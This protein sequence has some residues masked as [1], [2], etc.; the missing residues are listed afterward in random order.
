MLEIPHSK[1]GLTNYIHKKEHKKS[2]SKITTKTMR[3]EINKIRSE[4][5]GFSTL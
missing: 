5:G 3:N 4:N 1:S 2:Y